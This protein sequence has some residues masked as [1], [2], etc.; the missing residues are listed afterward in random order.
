MKLKEEYQEFEDLYKAGF[1]FDPEEKIVFVKDKKAKIPAK[2]NHWEVQVID[3]GSYLKERLE[4]L[5]A[6]EED[7]TIELVGGPGLGKKERCEQRIF[8]ANEFGDI[9]IL[10]YGLDRIPHSFYLNSEKHTTSPN[11]EK[12]HVQKRLAPWHEHIMQGKYDFQNAKNVPFWPKYLIEKFENEEA[13]DTLIITEGQIKAF[14]AGIN[15]FPVVGLTSITHYQSGK[16][17]KN[18]HTEIIEFINQCKVKRVV[19]L[20]DGDCLSISDKDLQNGKE[21]TRRPVLFKNSALAIMR[22]IEKYSRNVEV[23]FAMINLYETE[24]KG[25]DDLL[26]KHK[27]SIEAIRSDFNAIGEVPGK[28]IAYEQIKGREAESKLNQFFHLK[29]VQQFY[30]FHEEKIQKKDFVFF[31]STYYINEKGTPTI[32]VDKNLK[33]YKLIGTNFFK[34]K[35]TPITDKDGEVID[36]T[37]NLVPWKADIIKLQHG[38][39]ALKNIEVFQ[40]FCN[41]ASHT[42][43]QQVI[44][45]H[46][47]LYSDIEHT[48]EPGDFPNID[49]LLKHIFEEHFDN[50][51]IYDYFSILYTMPYE[52]LPILCLFSE[53]EGTGKS[54]F[55]KLVKMIF[56]QN[57]AIITSEDFMGNWNDHWISKLVVGSEETFFE[58]PQALDKLKNYSL[59]ETLIRA[60]RFVASQEIACIMKFIFNTNHKNFL[61]LTRRSTRFWIRE[62]KTLG[63]KQDPEFDNKIREEIKHFVDFICKR[64]L[65]H[66]KVDRMF[67]HPSQYHTSA[68]DTVIKE[69]EPG[70]VKDLRDKLR[71]LFYFNGDQEI[72]MTV[73]DLRDHFRIRENV[74]DSYLRNTVL[75][76]HLQVDLARP[77][78]WEYKFNVPKPSNPSEIMTVS[79][80]GRPFVFYRKDFIEKE[81]DVDTQLKIET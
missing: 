25:L 3:F 51:L 27:G 5:G 35:K 15:E 45:N 22:E 50:Q 38:N 14:M 80:S 34:V 58:K 75:R 10:Q 28:Y 49:R 36:Y 18:I 59:A 81:E 31:G 23:Y 1:V 9:E 52:K 60:E 55:M 63:G 32:K 24:S 79:G 13:V 66:K 73:G 72:Y 71:E 33:F 16:V 61:K 53:E 56:K 54:T 74:G 17:L 21:L 47:N 19:I 12:Y 7:N 8:T 43:Y 40:G 77:H 44:G 78:P 69:T 26:I 20:W 41:V 70:I 48:A 64:E 67:F 29:K 62:V 68:L 6:T 76:E 2:Y 65:A 30:E 46:W 37:E 11:R 42:N 39:D 4:E 57:M